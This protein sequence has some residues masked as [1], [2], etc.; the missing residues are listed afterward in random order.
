MTWDE[1]LKRLSKITQSIEDYMFLFVSEG[2]DEKEVDKDDN[3]IEE[4]V[5]LI[6]IIKGWGI[7]DE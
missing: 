1:L 2:I 3:N 4:L 6:R 7:N 5:E